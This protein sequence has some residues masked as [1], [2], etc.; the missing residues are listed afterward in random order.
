MV[1]DLRAGTED[2]DEAFPAFVSYFVQI[3]HCNLL[4]QLL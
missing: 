1:T 2:F 3:A 4:C